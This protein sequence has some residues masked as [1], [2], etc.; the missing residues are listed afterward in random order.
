MNDRQ[1]TLAKAPLLKYPVTLATMPPPPEITLPAGLQH[2]VDRCEKVCD[3]RCCGIDAYDFSPLHVASFLTH[4]GRIDPDL[5][6][7]WN[8]ILNDLLETVSDLPAN[9]A[10]FICSVAGMNQ[11][12]TWQQF[13]DFIEEVRSSIYAAPKM[14]E[15]SE[16]LQKRRPK[17]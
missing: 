4:S 17:R 8:K 3:A 1:V 7:G 11:Y 16:Q 2:L 10:G 6:T 9:E 13:N 15:F 14:L 5:I 12:F